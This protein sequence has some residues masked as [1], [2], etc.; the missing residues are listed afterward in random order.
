MNKELDHLYNALF[1]SLEQEYELYQEL[2]ESIK[3]ETA[4]L[5]SC[6]ATDISDFNS[7]NETIL[8]SLRRA[9]E[10][11]SATIKKI[12]SHLHLDEPVAMTQLIAYAQDQ[13]RQR[14]INYQEKFADLILQIGAAN[15]RSRDMIRFSLSH[16]NNTLNYINSLISPTKNYDQQG[17]VKAGN[18]QGRLI[19]K[20]G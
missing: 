15:N 18:L 7:R 11:R 4:S 5:K 17:K 6:T 8:H 16:I 12:N 1:L 10:I 19:S 3:E 14:M 20:A 13:T 2:L 9:S